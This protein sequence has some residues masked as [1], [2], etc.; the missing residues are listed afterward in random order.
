MQFT[1]TAEDMHAG[2]MEYEE[3]QDVLRNLERADLLLAFAFPNIFPQPQN[4]IK[5]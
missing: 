5:Q 4:T 2:A 3:Q 1:T